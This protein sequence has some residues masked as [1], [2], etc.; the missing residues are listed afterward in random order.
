MGWR[1]KGLGEERGDFVWSEGQAGEV[2]QVKQV[3]ML[4]GWPKDSGDL[5]GAWMSGFW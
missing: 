2:E 5:G 4:R 3:L 1:L